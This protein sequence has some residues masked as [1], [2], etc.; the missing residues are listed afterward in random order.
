MLQENQ[1]RNPFGNALQDVQVVP[2]TT[3]AALPDP[4]DA[5]ALGQPAAENLRRL[6][7]RYLNH[8]D[9][10]IDM[11]RIEPGSPGRYKVVIVLEMADFL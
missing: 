11:V 10:Q 9:S 6:A 1:G 8:P 5:P 4:S 7:S 3:R 2:D